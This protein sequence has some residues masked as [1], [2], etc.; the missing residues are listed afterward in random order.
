[1]TARDLINQSEEP[2]KSQMLE[3]AHPITIMGEYSRLS[4]CLSYLFEW[5]KSPQGYLYWSDYERKLIA[6]G[7]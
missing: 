6:L 4:V 3:N 7:L 5:N 1:M 2:Y